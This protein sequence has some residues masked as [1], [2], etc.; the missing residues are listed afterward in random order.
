MAMRTTLCYIIYT[1]GTTGKPKGVAVEHPSICNFVGVAAEVY[2]VA[3]DDRVYQGMTIAFD[4]SVE[5]IW[6]PLHSGATL[7]AAPAGPAGRAGT[8]PVPGNQPGYRPVLRPDAPGDPR[9]RPAAARASWCP[10]RPAR[11][12]V[13]RWHRGQRIL[14]VYGPTEATVTAT[15]RCRPRQ[16]RH[17]RLPLPTYKSLVSTPGNPV[18]RAGRSERSASRASGGPR[19][20]QPARADAKRLHPGLSRHRDNPTAGS[21][22][23]ATS[24]ASPATAR[25]STS[26]GSTPR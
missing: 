7:V 19:L 15:G 21:T 17:H 23:P 10:A 12:L 6:V 5:E 20:R 16:A 11:N 22:G 4:F 2:G 14:N 8:L 18:R 1:S 3:P 25:S 26:A 9:R 13:A 24:A